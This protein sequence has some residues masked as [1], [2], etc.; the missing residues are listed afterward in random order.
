MMFVLLYSTNSNIFDT[1]FKTIKLIRITYKLINVIIL[2][3]EDKH[4]LY[5]V[6][7]HHLY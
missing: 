6:Y 2:Y 5:F 7:F 3:N 1:S 4:K